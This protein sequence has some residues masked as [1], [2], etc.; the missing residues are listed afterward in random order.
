VV[1]RDGL[2]YLLPT[3]IWCESPDHPLA[4]TEL[5]FPFASVVELPG[6]ELLDRLGP[7]LVGTVLTQDGTFARA[8]MGCRQVERLNLG[9]LPTS[10]VSWEQPHEGNI[11]T[12]LYRR[13]AFQT[14][15]E[16]GVDAA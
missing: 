11:F 4:A 6:E 14:V 5:L 16:P 2:T 12:H 8:A 9:S 15:V 7:T 3:L 13:R 10:R 1:E